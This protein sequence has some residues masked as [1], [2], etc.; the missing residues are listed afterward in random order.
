MLDWVN[1][2]WSSTIDPLWPWSGLGKATRLSDLSFLDNK[3][4]T[5]VYI[6]VPH[7]IYSLSIMIKRVILVPE[8]EVGIYIR[9]ET[10]KHLHL[11]NTW[12]TLSAEHSI[13]MLRRA[14]YT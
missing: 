9:L 3:R 2:G 7:C 13:L 5:V 6:E 12:A 14:L 1:G 8:T 4:F 11:C 10:Y